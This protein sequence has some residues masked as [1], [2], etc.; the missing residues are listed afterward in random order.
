MIEMLWSSSSD[1]SSA[2]C[3]D[4]CACSAAGSSGSTARASSASETPCAAAAE[5]VSKPSRRSSTFCAV[6]TSNVANVSSPPRSWPPSCAVPVI[7]KRPSG[8][9]PLA[10]I[11]SPIP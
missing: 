5:I 9:S 3:A 4:V 1:A 11:A 7:V 6:G 8:P 2:A 10:P